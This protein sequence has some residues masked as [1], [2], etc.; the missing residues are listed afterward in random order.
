MSAFCNGVEDLLATL[1]K[2]SAE[3]LKTC[4]DRFVWSGGHV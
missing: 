2:I 4:Y 3:C 1:A